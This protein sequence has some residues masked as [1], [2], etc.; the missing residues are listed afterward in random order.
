MKLMTPKRKAA[1]LRRPAK[2]EGDVRRVYPAGSVFLNPQAA[3]NG[4][5][6]VQ[7]LP[8]RMRLRFPA[9][10]LEIDPDDDDGPR[11]GDDNSD[12]GPVG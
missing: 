8:G 5:V 3:G 12:S 10:A 6:V 11:D 7:I 9:D 1:R 4:T 2:S